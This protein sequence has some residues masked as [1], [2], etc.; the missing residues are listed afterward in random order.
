MYATQNDNK[1][2]NK[3]NPK[4]S[5]KHHHPLIMETEQVI[6]LLLPHVHEPL[7]VCLNMMDHAHATAI[8]KLLPQFP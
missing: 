8:K 1:K 6:Y 4:T 2:D 3:I 5:F 7:H